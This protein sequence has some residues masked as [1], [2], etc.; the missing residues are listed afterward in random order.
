[1]GFGGL[2]VGGT[3]LRV[4]FVRLRLRLAREELKAYGLAC[5]SIVLQII[6]ALCNI[7][8]VNTRSG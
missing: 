8:L 7:E 2:R 6:A 5:S 3:G 1:M 4:D